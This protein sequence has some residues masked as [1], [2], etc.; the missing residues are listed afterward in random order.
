MVFITGNLAALFN[1]G[2]LNYHRI[3]KSFMALVVITLPY[4]LT[5]TTG[6]TIF[7]KWMPFLYVLF[8]SSTINY[9]VFVALSE[10]G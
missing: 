6:K 10:E 5:K 8:Q 2:I 7:M 3:F 1:G 9:I 4:M